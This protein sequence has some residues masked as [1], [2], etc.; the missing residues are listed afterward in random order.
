MAMCYISV[1]HTGAELVARIITFA[2]LGGSYLRRESPV[3]AVLGGARSGGIAPARKLT[4]S[5][6]SVLPQA[7]DLL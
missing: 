4:R 3:A 5:R 2:L 1:I 6:P 7:M